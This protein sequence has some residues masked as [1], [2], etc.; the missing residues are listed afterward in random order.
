MPFF[1]A[2]WGCAVQSGRLALV[3]D[4]PR[5]LV[6]LMPLYWV[7]VVPEPASWVAAQAKRAY[8]AL[9][10][11]PV[12]RVIKRGASGAASKA[13]SSFDRSSV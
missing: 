7:E 11:A 10:I 13:I 3:R 8:G 12:K 6:Y 2:A 4:A 1:F 9:L 5:A